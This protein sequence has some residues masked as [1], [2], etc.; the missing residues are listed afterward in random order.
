MIIGIDARFYGPISKGLGRYT[1]EIVD[2]I[3]KIDKVNKYVI[4]LGPEN[5]QTFNVIDSD[6]TN[7]AHP[8]RVK[9]VMVNIRWY[10]FKEQLLFPFYIWREHLDLMHFPHFN[11]PLACPVKFIVTIHDLILIKYPTLRATTLNWLFYKIKNLVYRLVILSAI[12]RAKKIIAVSEFTKK[13]IVHQFK[14]SPEKIVVTYQGVA[15]SFFPLDKEGRG[16]FS[17]LDKKKFLLDYKITKPY[18]FYVGNAYPHKNLEGLIKVFQRVILKYSNLRLVLVGKEDYFYNRLK[19]YAKELNLWLENKTN[20]KIAFLGF[21]PDDKLN[22]LYNQAL[23]YIFPSFY[24]GFGLPPLEA[25][26]NGCPVISSNRTSMPE[27]LGQ[28]ACYF[29]PGDQENMF[30]QIERLINDNNLRQQLVNRGYE[31]V[32]KYSWQNCVKKTLEVYKNV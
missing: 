26:A 7:S 13:D 17:L 14:I 24:E 23:F 28:S 12:K 18:L 30:Q 1:Q 5:Y 19:N 16:D 6:Y 10:G 2:N 31:Q 27:I 25:M 8:N 20:S 9:K 15:K 4:F 3:I 21:I 32:Q 29:N 11:V 22:I